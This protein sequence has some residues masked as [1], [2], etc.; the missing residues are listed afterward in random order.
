MRETLNILTCFM[1]R[2]LLF[3]TISQTAATLYASFKYHLYVSNLM[4]KSTYMYE[5][6]AKSLRT[7]LIT[8]YNLRPIVFVFSQDLY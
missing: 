8:F 6:R 2:V 7:F 1:T 5:G 3:R 4:Y